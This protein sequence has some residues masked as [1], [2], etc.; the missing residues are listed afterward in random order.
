MECVL[1]THFHD[2]EADDGRIYLNSEAWNVERTVG[3]M[4]S[5]Q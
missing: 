4:G 5:R 1:S 3:E 2:N